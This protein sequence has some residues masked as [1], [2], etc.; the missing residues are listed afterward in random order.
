MIINPARRGP[1]GPKG[2][3]F[4]WDDLTPE[5]L[6]ALKG[7]AGADG[8][9][10]YRQAVDGGYTG[11]EEAFNLLLASGPWLPL[12]GGQLGGEL[13]MGFFGLRD[14]DSVSFRN[15]LVLMDGTIFEATE[16]EEEV[17]AEAYPDSAEGE[18][19]TDDCSSSSMEMEE[20]T[21][22]TEETTED[23]GAAAGGPDAEAPS[24]DAEEEV[25]SEVEEP[26]YSACLKLAHGPE[27]EVLARLKV[28]DPEEADDAATRGYVD[29]LRTYVDGLLGEIGRMLDTING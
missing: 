24:E 4:T 14:A 2:E 25:P 19:A 1:Q 26:D 9:S 3:P 18:A 11:T 12:S 28:A 8:K 7:P 20:A 29:A 21:M 15:G 5:Q 6:E 27:G 22:E 13:S 17:W 23:G 10:A 16:E